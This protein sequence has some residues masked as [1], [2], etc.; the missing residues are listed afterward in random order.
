M[1]KIGKKRKIDARNDCEYDKLTISCLNSQTRGGRQSRAIGHL[2]PQNTNDMEGSAHL[3][4]DRLQSRID[5]LNRQMDEELDKSCPNAAKMERWER[6]LRAKE[7]ELRAALSH[8]RKEA[9][10]LAEKSDKEARLEQCFEQ[11]G[12]RELLRE[13]LAQIDELL[14]ARSAPTHLHHLQRPA[15]APQTSTKAETRPA[16]SEVR[17]AAAPQTSTKAETRPVVSEVRPAAA[18]QTSTKAETR[19]VVSEVRP[20]AAPQ[21]STK[22]ET[23]PVPLKVEFKPIEAKSPKP[24]T[25]IFPAAQKV[26]SKPITPKAEPK[27]SP[28]P[29]PET[30]PQQVRKKSVDSDFVLLDPVSPNQR[31]KLK[32]GNTIPQTESVAKTVVKD[33][34]LLP[35]DPE[36]RFDMDNLSEENT[37]NIKAIRIGLFGDCGVGKS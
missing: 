33:L 19:P 29:V 26:V 16:V 6:E 14:Y 10:L 31:R 30:K 21:T 9:A 32:M 13:R 24:E 3:P 11:P 25:N 15:A 1:T 27:P 28:P 20:A 12:L 5:V 18:P 4:S 37:A 2:I 23:R 36:C 35:N 8:E 22:A 34:L 7:E 17:P